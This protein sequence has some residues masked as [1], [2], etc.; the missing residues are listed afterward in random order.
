MEEIKIASYIN[1]VFAIEDEPLK[2][3]RDNSSR[4]GLPTITIGAHEGRFL[5][6]LV[7]ACNAKK[8]LE[9][10][11]LG[12][13]SGIWIA[14]GLSSGG[15]LITFEKESKHAMVAQE[16]FLKAGLENMVE[17]RTGDAHEQLMAFSTEEQ[18][19]FIFIDAEKS[20]YSDYFSWAVEHV[21][22]GGLITAHNVLAYGRLLDENDKS[23]KIE[24]IRQF[25]KN[26]SENQRFFSTIYPVGDGILAAV[27]VF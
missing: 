13:Y 18:F 12:G 14:R 11:T 15:E 7:R 17:I 5:Q 10:G 4:Q 27:K 23:E 19:D 9:I 20:G 22:V 2:F 24:R 6:I 16:N 8:A 26:V 21:R 3:A 1:D 25:N